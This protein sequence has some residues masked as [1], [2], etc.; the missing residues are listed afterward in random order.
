MIVV[1][2]PSVR[3]LTLGRDEGFSSASDWVY[4]RFVI[5]FNFFHIYDS[6]FLQPPLTKIRLIVLVREPRLLPQKFLPVLDPL[7]SSVRPNPTGPA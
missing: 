4:V 6:P 7:P 5:L 1:F 3:N 2:A